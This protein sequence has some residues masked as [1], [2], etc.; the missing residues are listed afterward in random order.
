M[1]L[2]GQDLLAVTR[3][4]WHLDRRQLTPIAE[5]HSPEVANHDVALQK[6]RPLCQ[7]FWSTGRSTAGI[8]TI[9]LID[10]AS[11]IE[12]PALNCLEGPRAGT[13]SRGK[14]RVLRRRVGL[15]WR[16]GFAEGGS[17]C[18][19]AP[20]AGQKRFAKPASKHARSPTL[21]YSTYRKY[22]IISGMHLQP[23]EPP[24]HPFCESPRL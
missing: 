19:S 12:S 2:P 13:G 15:G 7:S 6:P 21:I 16:S 24:Q 22:S 17:P 8:C 4:V 14:F 3:E 18:V 23:V 20:P 11:S 9:Q 10:L 5:T 1:W